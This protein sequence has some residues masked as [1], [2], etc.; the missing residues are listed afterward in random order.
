MKSKFILAKSKFLFSVAYLQLGQG[1]PI[2]DMAAYT[3]SV[4]SF[5][6]SLQLI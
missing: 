6:V 5:W 3:K 2:S 1:R 4:T